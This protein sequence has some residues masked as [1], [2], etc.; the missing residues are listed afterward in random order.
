V[1]HRSELTTPYRLVHQHA[2]TF[3]AETVIVES[4]VRDALRNE[5][6]AFAE[7]VLKWLQELNRRLHI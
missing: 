6:R 4:R 3:I 2:A 1:R 7:L 5:K